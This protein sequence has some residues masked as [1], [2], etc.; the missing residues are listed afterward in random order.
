MAAGGATVA[1]PLR[2]RAHCAGC[3]HESAPDAALLC[4]VAQER[5]RP[6]SKSVEKPRAT[7][8]PGPASR[9]Q[10]AESSSQPGF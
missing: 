5:A 1:P 9:S 8:E 10:P 7:T 3:K 2:R 6:R 4:S